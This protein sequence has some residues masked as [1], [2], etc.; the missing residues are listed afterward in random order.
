MDAEAGTPLLDSAGGHGSFSLRATFS[1][2]LAGLLAVVLALLAVFGEYSPE[3]DDAHV[4]R[5]YPFLTDV[6]VIG[7]KQECLG[8]RQAGAQ[9]QVSPALRPSCSHLLK[10][11]SSSIPSSLRCRSTP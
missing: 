3:L 9:L 1:A 4:T 11:A 5:Y 6:S 2:P 7:G 8:G 10:P